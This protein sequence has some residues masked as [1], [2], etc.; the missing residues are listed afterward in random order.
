MKIL[1]LS[2]NKF[3][4]E[5]LKKTLNLENV[6]V[7]NIITLKETAKTIMH[8]GIDKN[9]WHKFGINVI[10]IED[11][12]QEK[13]LLKKINPDL[14]LLCGWRQILTKEILNI[15]KHGVIGFHPTLLPHGRGPAP[16]INSIMFGIKK[17]GVTMFYISEGIDD[18]DIIGQE[19]FEIKNE[20]YASDVYKKVIDSGE[21]LI[22]KYLPQIINGDAPR[23]PQDETEAFIFPKPKLENNKINFEKESIEEIHKKI[24][25]LSKPYN[26]A[27][28]EKDGK[29]LVIWKAEMLEK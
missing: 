12:N 20:D 7:E 22:E 6:K 19:F 28:V 14:I 11:I 3:G 18:G 10:E 2:A 25:A 5:L 26:G 29:K 13:Q 17:T 21:K 24:R 1:W 9:K 4:Y 23:I 15:P 8:D 16:I 27:Y